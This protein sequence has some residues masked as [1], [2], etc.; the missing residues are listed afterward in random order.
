MQDCHFFDCLISVSQPDGP[1]KWMTMTQASSDGTK[2]GIESTVRNWCRDM[3]KRTGLIYFLQRIEK[4]GDLDDVI[5]RI[6][7]EGNLL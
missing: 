4:S 7:A 6:E 3:N 2:K 5:A 1:T